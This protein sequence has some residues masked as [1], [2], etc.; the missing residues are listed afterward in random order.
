MIGLDN[1][2]TLSCQEQGPIRGPTVVL[3]P[4]PTDSWR[5]YDPVLASL[6]GSVRCV[7]V[8]LRGH[9]D[10][11]QPETGYRIQD[12]ASD[13]VPLLDVLGIERAVLAGHSGSCLVAR[14]VALDAPDRV[15]GLVLEAS[16]TTLR[17]DAALLRFV[18]SVV[19]EL[20]SPI[21]RQ[22]ARSFIAD[23]S[24]DDLA[25]EFVDVLVEDLLKVP[26]VAWRE[27]FASLVEYDDTTDLDQIN[28]PVTLVW[29]DADRLVTREAQE[30]QVRL[31]PL[32]DLRVYEGV[33]HTPRWEQP[34][35]FALDVARFVSEVLPE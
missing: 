32:A 14:R 6:P 7:A 22:F 16:P 25:P 9:G 12:L 26:V 11:S 33:G 30:E 8:S 34:E 21:D 24:V 31:L 17:G 28:A 15:G 2:L 1:G 10:S 18:E 3:L 35:R 29:G 5:S 19:A 4:G 13:V 27:M 23:T 20:S